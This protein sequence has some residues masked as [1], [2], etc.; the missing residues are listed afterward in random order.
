VPSARGSAPIRT[1]PS[2]YRSCDPPR[3]SGARAVW[4]GGFSGV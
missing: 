3:P 2:R 1:R 4:A